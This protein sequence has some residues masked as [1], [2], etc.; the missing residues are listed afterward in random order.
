M[1]VIMTNEQFYIDVSMKKVEG[2]G[3]KCYA[4]MFPFYPIDSDIEFIKNRV[5]NNKWEV[6]TLTTR[7]KTITW[8]G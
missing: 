7:T 6:H 8:S 2:M 4:F 5:T 3:I 1:G